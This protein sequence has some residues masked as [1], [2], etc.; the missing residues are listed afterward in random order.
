MKPQVGGSVNVDSW[1]EGCTVN[2]VTLESSPSLS[3][4]HTVT[5]VQLDS[6]VVR[7]WP[8]TGN[9][10]QCCLIT[11]RHYNIHALKMDRN[12]EN[13]WIVTKPGPWYIPCVLYM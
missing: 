6:G 1:N 13:N 7:H 10:P 11:K 5:V 8:L 9:K 12:L 3:L 4:C 2:T